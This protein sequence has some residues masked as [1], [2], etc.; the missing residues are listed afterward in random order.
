[1]LTENPDLYRASQRARGADESLIDQLIEADAARRETIA[2]FTIE[3]GETIERRV[4]TGV[5]I[6]NKK[7]VIVR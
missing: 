2:T 7:K 4:N 6:V 1:M 5:Y 3:S